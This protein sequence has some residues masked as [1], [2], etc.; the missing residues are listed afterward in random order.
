MCGICG[1]AGLEDK[2]LVKKMASAIAHRGPDADGVFTDEGISLAH[3]RLAIIDLSSRGK[4]PM[5]NEEGTAWVVFNGEIYN[6]PQLKRFLKSN[7]KHRFKSESDTEVLVHAF[8]EWGEEF[9]SRLRGDFAFALWDS[10]RENLLLARDF[11]G[12][13]PLYYHHDAKNKRLYFASEIKSILQAGVRRSVNLSAVNDFLSFQYSIGPETMFENIFKVQPGEL[14]VFNARKNSLR[15][16]K[17]RSLANPP[18]ESKSEGEWAGEVKKR[19]SNSVERR[20]LSDVPLGVFLSGGLDSSFTAA[21]MKSLRDEVKTFSVSFGTGS[22][23]D[24]FS[25]LVAEHLGTDHTELNVDASDYGAFPQVAWHLD[26]PAADIAA[27]PTFLMAKEAKKHVTVILTGDGGDEVFG[28]YERYSRL[29]LLNKWSK[30]A[31]LARFF[32]P[33]LGYFGDAE[34]A[35]EILENSGN[36]QKLLVSYSAALSENEKK[37]FSSVLLQG[38]NHTLEKTRAF[39]GRQSFL[40]QMMDFDL[41]TLLPD[42]YL[43]KVNKASMAHALEPRVPF[44][45]SDFIAFTQSIPPE[46]KVSGLKTK[47]LLRRTIARMLPKEISSR[48]KQGFNVPTRAWLAGGLGEIAEQM[49]SDKQTRKRGLVEPEFVKKVLQKAR[50]REVL[51][52]KRFWTLFALEAWQRIFIDSDEAAKPSGFSSLGV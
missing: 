3:K 38:K 32:P 25:R 35:G 15:K 8:E 40:K 7:G 6:F 24:K 52:G 14:V 44:L 18:F 9:V 22:E 31:G 39:F 20:L 49:L 5:C 34:R 13:C 41:Q 47:V 42:D 50:A 43:M 29:A 21:T 27:L 12:I 45:D 1:M 10:E 4:Q 48:G 37:Q 28:G 19:F 16:K 46:L 23:D 11:P 26:E 17:F 33:A 2:Q 51:W 36:G 30:A